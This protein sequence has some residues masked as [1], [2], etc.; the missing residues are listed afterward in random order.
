MCTATWTTD[1]EGRLHVFFSRDERRSR[2]TA[3]PPRVREVDG[4]RILAPLDPDGGGTWILGNE[5]GLGACLLNAWTEEAAAKP[6][7][8]SRG[9]LLMD[10]ATARKLGEARDRLTRSVQK[11]RYAPFQI[12]ILD[13]EGA[14]LRHHWN[15][16]ELRAR[17][18]PVPP[19]VVS[20]AVSEEEVRRR[21][22]RLLARLG[23]DVE[24]L[25]SFHLDPG[26]PDAQ[27]VRMSRPEARTVSLTQMTLGPGPSVR[28]RYWPRRGDGPFDDPVEASLPSGVGGAPGS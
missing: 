7:E 12:L 28:M 13:L 11:I 18:I 3:E 15:G 24:A 26:T 16:A 1:D 21:R 27:S 5:F 10:L 2:S 4:T 6:G 22:A 25:R 17:P 20:S 19:I 14:I 23:E 9:L 8:R